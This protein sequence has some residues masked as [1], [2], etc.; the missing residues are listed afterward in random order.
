MAKSK[1]IFILLLPLAGTLIFF[2]IAAEPVL[3]VAL[4]LVLA[5]LMVLMGG[6]LTL[7]ERKVLSTYQCRVGP[8][9]V[10]ER[11]RLQFLVDAAKV[12]FKEVIFLN[13]TSTRY[14]AALPMFFLLANSGFVYLLEFCDRTTT[15]N[16]NYLPMLMLVLLMVSNY[17]IVMVGQYLKNRYTRLAATRAASMGVSIDLLFSAILAVL[18]LVNGTLEYVSVSKGSYCSGTVLLLPM[19]PV[20]LITVLADIGKPPFDVVESESE[21]IMGVHSD[22]SGFLFV[23]WLLGEYLHIFILSVFITN[24]LL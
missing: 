24:L 5:I 15:Q 13:K 18:A 6:A 9:I 14:V 20:L 3:G 16:A 21:L 22:M 7:F 17:L 19:V 23:V 1:K 2:I 8:D 4:V 11:G 10:G 12:L